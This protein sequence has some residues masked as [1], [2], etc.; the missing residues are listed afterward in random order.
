ME[1]V[2]GK[3]DFA[4]VMINTPKNH[5]IVVVGRID[6]SVQCVP[7]RCAAERGLISVVEAEFPDC[8]SCPSFIG[9]MR[10]VGVERKKRD[11]ILDFWSKDL[12]SN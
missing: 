7:F 8:L 12:L 2:Y 6:G 11:A 1:R 10:M 3:R 5:N 9:P 4:K